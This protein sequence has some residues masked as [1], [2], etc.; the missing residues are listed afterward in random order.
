MEMERIPTKSKIKM[1]T[2]KEIFPW[3]TDWSKLLNSIFLLI[4]KSLQNVNV[5]TL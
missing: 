5:E 3:T 4:K 1:A 2:S